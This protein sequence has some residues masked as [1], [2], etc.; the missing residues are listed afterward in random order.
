MARI[1][2]ITHLSYF[3]ILPVLQLCFFTLNRLNLHLVAREEAQDL[4]GAR[5]LL[6]YWI[7]EVRRNTACRS[8]CCLHSVYHEELIFLM[9]YQSVNSIRATQWRRIMEQVFTLAVAFPSVELIECECK[10]TKSPWWL[11]WENL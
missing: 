9:L 3:C 1:I 10:E 7:E 11:L 2:F 4:Q 6:W 5:H 8:V